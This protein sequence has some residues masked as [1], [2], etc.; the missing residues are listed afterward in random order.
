MGTGSTVSSM[1][2]G[3]YPSLSRSLALPR[4][5]VSHSSLSLSVSLPPFLTL[6]L[7]H[8]LFLYRSLSVNRCSLSLSVNNSSFSL[9]S[10]SL[11]SLSPSLS[12]YL[13]LCQQLLSLSQ[14]LI[15]SILSFASLVCFLPL[16]CLFFSVL[17]AR[18]LPFHTVFLCSV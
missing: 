15:I 5:T 13:A 14:I 2:P 17:F 11:S 6:S 18:C 16:G 3:V 9:I 8:S 1:L 7:L 4:L 12:M 10:R